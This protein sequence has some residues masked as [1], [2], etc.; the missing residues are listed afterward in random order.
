MSVFTNSGP[1][2]SSM[3]QCI[4]MT[5]RLFLPPFQELLS[6]E[7]NSTAYTKDTK[8]LP[9]VLG[10]L[11]CGVDLEAADEVGL[12]NSSVARPSSNLACMAAMNIA[13][14]VVG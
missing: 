13:S 1:K 2:S 3:V 7:E 11:E 8:E 6:F 10:V 14:L 5:T 12:T 9:R 4:V